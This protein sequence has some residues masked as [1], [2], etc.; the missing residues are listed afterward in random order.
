MMRALMIALVLMVLPT[1]G[2]A[3]LLASAGPPRLGLDYELIE[4]PHAPFVRGPGIEIAEVFS[5]RCSHCAQFQ[6]IVNAWRKNQPR[7]VRWVYVP[8]A[9][10]G[11]W[12]S[13]ARA[14]YAAESLG[15]VDKTHDAVFK[16]I[17]VDH[18]IQ[19]G[20]AD[21]LADMYARFGVDRPRFLAE[22]A[23][24]ATTTRLAMAKEFA[25]ATGIKGT[26]TLIVNGKYRLAPTAD[27]GFDGLIS[28][29]NFVLAK[30]RV[31]SHPARKG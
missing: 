19:T 9:F 2:T 5:Y 15:V 28:A 27:R 26:P 17:F 20:T 25:L 4:K 30:E 6:P 14:Y 7:D 22:M 3:Q 8:A 23:D 16:A 21:E 31:E 29:L 10:G 13:F 11:S 18:L 12:D 24:A 1:T